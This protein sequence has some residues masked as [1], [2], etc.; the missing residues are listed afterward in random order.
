MECFICKE[1]LGSDIKAT[2]GI[3]FVKTISIIVFILISKI[4]KSVNFYG[5]F[6]AKNKVI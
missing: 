4:Q 5:F 3:V 1:S 2:Q 6:L